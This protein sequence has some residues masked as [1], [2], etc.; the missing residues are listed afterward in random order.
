MKIESCP[1]G[2]D[3]KLKVTMAALSVI[4]ELH[5]RVEMADRRDRLVSD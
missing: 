5:D 2:K 1:K 3:A 4:N